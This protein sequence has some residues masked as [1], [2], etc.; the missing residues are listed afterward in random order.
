MAAAPALHAVVEPTHY[1]VQSAG[2][3]RIGETGTI[4]HLYPNG[5]MEVEF[6][7]GRLA[8]FL[9][10]TLRIHRPGRAMSKKERLA[11][12]AS[13]PGLT[14]IDCH[15]FFT[16]RPPGRAHRTARKRGR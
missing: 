16:T 14:L 6:N 13:I 4:I 15:D 9:P 8:T 2:D 12:L 7:H 1:P 10:G 3:V 11:A 5:A